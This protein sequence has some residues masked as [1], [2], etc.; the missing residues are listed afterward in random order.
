MFLFLDVVSPIPEFHLIND[1]KIQK[2]FK[3]MQNANQKLS[4]QIIPRYLEI[5]KTYNIEKKIK[6]L[7]VTIGP[8]SY[9]ALRVGTSF[10]AGLSQSMNL[11]VST[12][13]VETIYDQLYDPNNQ[14][15]IYFESS[16]NQNFF[17]YKE[18]SN[19]YNLKIDNDPY[20]I[21]ENISLV[22]FNKNVSNF[23]NTKVKLRAFSIKDTVL[24]LL[25]NLKFDDKS[26]IKPIYIS[27][28]KLLN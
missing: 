2:S 12:I 17:S 25:D 26:I 10:I 20:L 16:N 5:K 18:G 4:D 27:N 6:K 9:T 21:P 7:I 22:F 13:S 8:G 1:K 19:F 15:G 14:I 11:P 28:N 3:I 24:R 23:I